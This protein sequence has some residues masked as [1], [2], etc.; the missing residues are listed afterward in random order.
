MVFMDDVG[1]S[2]PK[3]WDDIC[4]GT[5]CKI[6]RKTCGLSYM[7]FGGELNKPLSYMLPCASELL[8]SYNY[9]TYSKS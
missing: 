3:E 8:S 1:K 5:R 2:L 7:V 9:N 6:P 4:S